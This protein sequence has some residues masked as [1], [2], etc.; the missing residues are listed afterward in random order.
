MTGVTR[1]AVGHI[2]CVSSTK[3]VSLSLPRRASACLAEY[4]DFLCSC[5]WKEEEA[6]TP[7][8]LLE[9]LIKLLVDNGHG[10]KCREEQGGRAAETLCPSRPCYRSHTDAL[11]TSASHSGYKQTHTQT[12]SLLVWTQPA[13]HDQHPHTTYQEERFH[14]SVLFCDWFLYTIS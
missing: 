5:V 13:T 8:E 11:I 7:C 9:P 6:S 2:H 14:R 12:V 10:E 1:G 4:I 3:I